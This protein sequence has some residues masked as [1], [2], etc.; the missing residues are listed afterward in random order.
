MIAGT[1]YRWMDL[2]NRPGVRLYEGKENDDEVILRYDTGRRVAH[3][4]QLWLLYYMGTLSRNKTPCYH[5]TQPLSDRG[6]VLEHQ[7]RW[8]KGKRRTKDTTVDKHST[9]TASE[10]VG[11]A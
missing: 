3:A 9:C 7:N 2:V 10:K 5:E 1:M 11:P 6:M 8:R 4:G